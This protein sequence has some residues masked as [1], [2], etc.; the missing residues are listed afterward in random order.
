MVME[1]LKLFINNEHISYF[2][3]AVGLLT[4][5]SQIPSYFSQLHLQPKPQTNPFSTTK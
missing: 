5:D 4:R 1:K 3:E 2:N